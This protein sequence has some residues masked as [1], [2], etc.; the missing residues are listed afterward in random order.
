MANG[1]TG[2]SGEPVRRLKK[3]QYGIVAYL[4]L[5]IIT[6][7]VEGFEGAVQPVGHAIAD[8]VRAVNIE[9]T[10]RHLQGLGNRSDW[11]K[12]W[13]TADWIGRNLASWGLKVNV[14]RYLFKGKEWPN[15]IATLPGSSSPSEMILVIA[16][17][18]STADNKEKVMPGA[19]DDGSGV[20]VL[21]EMAR[22][23]SRSKP[24]RTIVFCVFSNEERGAEGSRNYARKSRSAGMDIRAVLS[25]DVLGYNRPKKLIYTKAFTSHAMI[26]HKVKA[27]W[28]MARNYTLGFL[29][30]ENVVLVGGRMKNADLVKRVAGVLSKDHG[31]HVKAVIDDDCG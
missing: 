6:F 28:R 4:L 9:N 30:G 2:I 7:S 21:L 15:V 18:D 5:L 3:V 13:E 23:C 11:E 1:F 19:D 27:A 8:G 10:I 29:E 22:I 14:E 17:L 12:Q 20:A 25:L 16:H 26:K 31:T 24:D